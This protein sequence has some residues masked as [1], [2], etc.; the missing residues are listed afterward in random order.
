MRTRWNSTYDMI[1]VAIA[2]REAIDDVTGNKLIKLRKHELE[3]EHWAILKDLV[4]VLKVSLSDITVSTLCRCHCQLFK[5]ATLFFSTDNIETIAHVIPMM[6]RFDAMLKDSV[7]EPLAP[8]VRHAL[9]FAR[10]VMDKYYAKTDL[11]NMYRIAM[12][13]C[14]QSLSLHHSHQFECRQVL[15]PQM[16]LSY[17]RLHGWEQSWIQTA[18]DMVTDEF[19]KY[20]KPTQPAEVNDTAQRE[21]MDLFDIPMEAVPTVSELKVYL[22]QPIERVKDPIAWW[23][24]HRAVFPRLSVMALDYLSAPGMCMLPLRVDAFSNDAL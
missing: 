22:S 24:D 15:H 14:R 11:S 13:T 9:K 20:D 8:A 18:E 3:D 16:K 17:F 1:R 5:D 6:D 12:G 21:E 4:H 2:Y 23:W 10:N 19:V 7:T